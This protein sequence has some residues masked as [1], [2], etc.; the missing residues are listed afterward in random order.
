MV[1]ITCCNDSN[2]GQLLHNQSPM[3]LNPWV[4]P[5][6]V[7]AAA[8]AALIRSVIVDLQGRPGAVHDPAKYPSAADMLR[9]SAV[10]KHLLRMCRCVQYVHLYVFVQSTHLTRLRKT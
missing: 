2:G 9:D 8:W 3:A 4:N 1:T 6:L 5:Q 7:T 10:K